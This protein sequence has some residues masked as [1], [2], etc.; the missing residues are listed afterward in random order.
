MKLLGRRKE[1]VYTVTDAPRP[2]SEEIDA[3]RRRYLFWMG[4]RTLCFV[5]AIVLVLVLHGT[6]RVVAF[7]AVALPAIFL[8]MITVVFANAGREPG[9]GRFDTYDPAQ[10][11]REQLEASQ[12][13]ASQST[14]YPDAERSS[15]TPRQG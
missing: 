8:P 15:E 1:A 2:Y 4:I 5:L 9:G 11:D 14:A 6:A 7:F 3:R 13:E 10:E 12:R